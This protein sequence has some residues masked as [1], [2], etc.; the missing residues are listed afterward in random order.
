MSL[1]K[2]THHFDELLGKHLG[3]PKWPDTF[4][5]EAMQKI[6][7]TL[8]RTGV[9]LKSEARRGSSHGMAS[10]SGEAAASA[11]RPALPDLRPEARAE[12]DALLP[13][14]GGQRR[15]DEAVWER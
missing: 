3:N 2:L 14:V 1:Y 4:I 7:F 9:V 8:S 11:L 6:D 12:R 15:T 5:F 13:H 10:R